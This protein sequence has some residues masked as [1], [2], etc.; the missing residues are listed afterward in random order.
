M[1]GI[2]KLKLSTYTSIY[3]YIYIQYICTHIHTHMRNS[4]Y[5]L[6]L[7]EHVIIETANPVVYALL[8]FLNEVGF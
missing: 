5:I 3:I 6:A 8:D 1:P 4:A 2:P 7:M